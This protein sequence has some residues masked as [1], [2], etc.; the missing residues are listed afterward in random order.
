MPVISSDI[1][2][3]L[4]TD[5]SITQMMLENPCNT[6]PAKVICE[7]TLTGKTTTYGS[8]RTDAFTVAHSLRHDHGV[9][10]GDTVAII[11]R[12]SVRP[13]APEAKAPGSPDFSTD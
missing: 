5:R 6:D 3:H 1:T 8:L 2:V 10:A 11:G 13:P 12:S 7:D 9:S 4:R